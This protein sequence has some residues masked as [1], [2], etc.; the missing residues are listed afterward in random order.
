VFFH[1]GRGVGGCEGC[2]VAID[3]GEVV[4]EEAFYAAFYAEFFE[5]CCAG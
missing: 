1:W 4:L 2:G 5:G 3:G